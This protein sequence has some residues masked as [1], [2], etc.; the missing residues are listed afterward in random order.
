MA[1]TPARVAGRLLL[2]AITTNERLT[3]YTRR[4]CAPAG[5]WR[6]WR[7]VRC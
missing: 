1:V 3:G 4:W 2:V 6:R 7:S 5:A